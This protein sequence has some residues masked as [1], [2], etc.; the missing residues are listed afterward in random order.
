M[1]R[2][3]ASLFL[4]TVFTLSPRLSGASNPYLEIPAQ[5]EVQATRAHAYANLTN[6]EAFAELDRRGI[7]YTA[8]PPIRGVRA[9]IRLRGLLRGVS[10]HGVL[11]AEQRETSPYEVLDARLALALDDFCALL[12]RHEIV[13]LVHM[14]MYRPAGTRPEDPSAPQSRHPGGMAIDVGGFRKKNGRWLAVGPHWSSSV[15]SKTC[16]PGARELKSRPAREL[17][18]IVCEASDLRIFHY[19]LTPHFDAAHADHL[20]LEIKPGVKWFLV[21]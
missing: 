1:A 2:H 12:A 8:T 16:G 21:N 13:E 17:V 3:L 19:M 10:I 9:P 4:W 20:H 15:G 18:S 14:T 7:A 6:A 5:A 11:P